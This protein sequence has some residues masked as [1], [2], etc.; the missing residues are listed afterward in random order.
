M[1]TCYSLAILHHR[2]GSVLVNTTEK[3]TPSK[4]SVRLER[5]PRLLPLCLRQEN[6]GGL[7]LKVGTVF[8]STGKS[9]APVRPVCPSPAASAYVI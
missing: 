5:G 3:I 6:F 1:S 9:S 4:F 7:R 2:H 8:Q